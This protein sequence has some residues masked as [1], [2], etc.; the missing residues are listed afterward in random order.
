MHPSI[1][2]RKKAEQTLTESESN[3]AFRRTISSDVIWMTDMDGHLGSVVHLVGLR[4]YT[5]EEVMKQSI[6]E[7]LTPASAKIVLE[8]MQN[9][10]KTAQIHASFSWNIPCKDRS[11]SLD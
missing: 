4:G 1:T 11:D 6:F 8:S 3:V 5:F 2:E 7:A 10:Q 9:F